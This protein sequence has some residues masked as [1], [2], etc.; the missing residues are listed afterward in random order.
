MPRS[1]ATREEVEALIQKLRRDAEEGFCGWLYCTC[2]GEMRLTTIGESG[3]VFGP[4][5]GPVMLPEDTPCQQCVTCG[6]A[7]EVPH[8]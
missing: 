1:D 6:R 4:Y 5:G 7:Y 2:E 3:V 8:G